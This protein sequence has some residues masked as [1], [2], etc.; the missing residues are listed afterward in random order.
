MSASRVGRRP[1][2]IPSGVEVKLQGQEL[3]IKGPKGHCNMP[4]HP[5][6]KIELDGNKQVKIL[7]CNDGYCRTGSGSKLND[8]ITGTMRAKINNL[9]QGV[10][11]GFERKLVLVGVGY[12]ASNN[13][14][15]IDKIVGTFRSRVN[16][17][18]FIKPMIDFFEYKSTELN[19]VSEN[20]EYNK[21]VWK[22]AQ[23]WIKT[24]ANSYLKKQ[25]N[26]KLLLPRRL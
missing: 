1:V 2:A 9:V 21:S 14:N 8:S 6:V 5:A 7:A 18:E 26:S 10:S 23:D 19:F 16:I 25:N 11:K 20:T 3:S 13:G 17:N 24:N 4:L 12:R 15:I 22:D